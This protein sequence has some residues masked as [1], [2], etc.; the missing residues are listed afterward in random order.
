[1]SCGQVALKN[2][3]TGFT[4]STGLQKALPNEHRP[5]LYFFNLK[6]PVNPV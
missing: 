4:G 1:M 2:Y 5:F 6:N 3:P